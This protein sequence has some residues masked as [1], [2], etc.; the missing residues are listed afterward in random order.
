MQMAMGRP[1][2]AFE[3]CTSSLQHKE[4]EN[5]RALLRRARASQSLGNYREA[6]ADLETVQV[7]LSLLGFQSTFRPRDRAG[8]T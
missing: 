3:D 2:K 6:V 4:Q 5:V 8:V 1:Q 7:R